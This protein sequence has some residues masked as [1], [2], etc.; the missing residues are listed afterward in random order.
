MRKIL[1]AGNWKMHKTNEEAK[2]LAQEIK[3]E[4]GGFTQ[5]EVV[6]CP[7]FT[8]LRSVYEV[9][10]ETN[11]KLGGQDLFWE[12]Q[13]AFTGEVSGYLLKDCGCE[14]VIIGHSERRK[15]MKETNEMV[16]KK[17]KSALEEKITPI[18]CV[19]ETLQERE[20]NITFEVIR[21]QLKEGLAGVGE[22]E[23]TKLVVAY[24]PVW[25]IGTGKTA[26]PQ[27]AEEVQGFIRK[28]I[29]D[30][31]SSSCAT[32][33]RILYGGSVNPSN[34]EMLMKEKDVDGAL[35]GGASLK[36]ETFVSIVKNAIG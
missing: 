33:I 3:Q 2:S 1:I 8:A 27:Q 5:G 30:N 20:K 13:G 16:N 32:E 31:F 28:W 7:P 10:K 34:I 6:L 29:S 19:G 18:L 24:E 23:I 11:L 4:L 26:T 36:A 35:V 17:I 12:K 14:F 15:Y 22:E 21:T 9:I 25:A